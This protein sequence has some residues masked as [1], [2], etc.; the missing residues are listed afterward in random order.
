MH[1]FQSIKKF[2]VLI[3]AGLLFTFAAPQLLF[4]Q[5]GGADYLAIIAKNTTEILQK[6]NGIPT[7]INKMLE[8]ILSWMAVDD[9]DDTA[10]MQSRFSALGTGFLNTA[11]AQNNYQRQIAADLVDQPVGDFTSPANSPKIL[12]LLPRVNDI[13]YSSLL[14][15]KP[16]PKG[17]FSAYNFVK[18]A[19][20]VNFNHD[21]PRQNWQGTADAKGN[22]TAYYNTMIAIESFNSYVLSSLAA[23]SESKNTNKALQ[24]QLV[25]QA[26]S[27]SWIAKIA[28]EELGK[29]LRQILMFQSQ[30]Y[31]L[32]TEM[33][34]T[35]KQLLTAVAMN[36]TLLILNNQLNE[37]L[38][39]SKAKGV[40]MRP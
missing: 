39:V 28:S 25:E 31:V 1:F 21:I 10:T 3:A 2:L 15:Q 38:M 9:S 32:M 16:A 7:Y 8:F 12:G 37:S 35:Q 34:Q 4:A 13:M 17:P 19:A 29:V 14:G 40:Q 5:E 20:G 23:E 36:N 24:N 22:Y 18:H 6:V 26:S 30:N 11:T 33:Q 27:S